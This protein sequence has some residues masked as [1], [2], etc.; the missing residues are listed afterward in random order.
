LSGE[1]DIAVVSSDSVRR[2]ESR[3]AYESHGQVSDIV[4]REGLA[5]SGEGRS[6]V[7][8]I[9]AAAQ[10]YWTGDWSD[11]E[12]RGGKS[13]ALRHRADVLDAEEASGSETR[14]IERK[15]VATA[16]AVDHQARCIGEANVGEAR[17]ADLRRLHAADQTAVG[18]ANR[19]GRSR[20]DPL[21]EVF[22]DRVRDE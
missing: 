13:C 20:P 17:T 19:L 8:N 4:E 3:N 12:V 18:D 11:D 2:A 6:E 5:G 10:C 22:P 21:E 9:V 15:R 14:V 16:A 7:G 1:R